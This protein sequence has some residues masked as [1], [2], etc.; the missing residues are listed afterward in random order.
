MNFRPRQ[1]LFVTVAALTALLGSSI[2][3][4][5]S[6]PTK[7]VRVVVGFAPGG[8]AD[9]FSRLIGQ[10]LSAR[11]GQPFIIENRPGDGSNIA[12]EVVVRASADGYTLLQVGPPHAINVSLYDKL[13]YNFIRDIAPVASMV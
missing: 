5:Q 8:P 12:T 2:A 13:N 3:T 7:P 6:Y 10:S 1:L 4:A 11:L 9:V